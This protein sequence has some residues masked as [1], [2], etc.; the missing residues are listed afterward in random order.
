MS[1]LASLNHANIAA[2]YGV[3]ESSGVNFMI[4][5]LVE[6][7]T[8]AER[9][10]RTGPLPVGETLRVMWEVAG[11]LEAAH[12]KSIAHRDIK[13]ANIKVT[14]EGRVKVL[15]LGLAKVLRSA[16]PQS[17]AS[18]AG[19]DTELGRILG[20]PRYMSPEQAR[21]QEVDGRTDI[22]AF[23]CLLYELLTARYA[24]TGQTVSDIL[25][26]IL[27]REPDY[28][29][30]PTATP[31]QLRRLIQQCLK[32]D[33]AA[34]L[35]DIAEARRLLEEAQVRPRRRLFTRRRL[36]VA[37]AAAALVVLTVGGLGDRWFGNRP[38]IRSI[39][40]LPL[41]NLSGNPEQEY[42]SDGM[43]ESLI[44][45]LAKIGALKVISRTS[46]MTYKGTN[47]PVRE[48]AKELKVDAVLEGSAQR[49][50]NRI[51]ITAKLIDARSEQ[52]L[53]AESY[54]H[55][56]ADVL[57]L[58]TEV[59]R[60]V[61][62]QVQARLTPKERKRL[63]AIGAVNPEAL[64]AYLQ[65]MYQWY[66][67]AHHDA[68]QHF[69]LALAKDPKNARA[70][71]GIA[72]VWTA[73]FREGLSPPREGTAKAMAALQRAL[74]LDNTLAEIHTA[75]ATSQML[76]EWDWN[77]AEA[78]YRRAIDLDPND[79]EARAAYASLLNALNRPAEAMIQIERALELD[80]LNPLIRGSYA[81]NLNFSFRYAEAEAE[82]RL[83]LAANPRL[84]PAMAALR[85][86]LLRQGK[87]KEVLEVH[88]DNLEKRGFHDLALVLQQG[89]EKGRYREAFEEAA[90]ILEARWEQGTFV[91]IGDIAALWDEAGRP[92]KCLDW[93]EKA[94]ERRQGNPAGM[95][96]MLPQGSVRADN[97]RFQAILRRAG[98]PTPPAR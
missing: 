64:Q 18:N 60:T 47:K 37:G 88:G 92:D 15:D 10:K 65:G 49:S 66:R 31:L 91:Q 4:L 97:P 34:R 71:A 75:L 87:I 5:E 50:G 1:G 53:W 56:F 74:A 82:A 84:R 80:P 81:V 26:S 43:T 55:D 29:K 93:W 76:A 67:G 45:D 33:P 11:A 21:G 7:E 23:G 73:R 2:I 24:L 72:R 54:N 51:R 78:E 12:R 13:P 79:A 63:A 22:W 62:Q 85:T 25:V 57:V 69:E 9:L 90:R 20:T 42:F 28:K 46:V 17:T 40:V 16:A 3:E 44:T 52:P 27:E 58:Q 89:Y 83:V 19:L 39:A 32:K 98:L 86:A 48:I 94:V 35:N 36:A 96:L 59:A 70:Y 14:P 30:L 6:G 95:L 77:G 68:Q 41:A 8:L 38:P 61:A